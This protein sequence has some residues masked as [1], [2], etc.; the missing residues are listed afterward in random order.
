MEP[1][2]CAE[3]KEEEVLGSRHNKSRGLGA[4]GTVCFQVVEI[5]PA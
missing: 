3:G 4:R 2:E 1:S 5:R